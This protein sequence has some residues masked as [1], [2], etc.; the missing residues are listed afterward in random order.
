MELSNQ[1]LVPGEF[2]AAPR[3]TTLGWG[4]LRER[5]R[6]PAL[7]GS[8]LWTYATT[9]NAV[10]NEWPHAPRL[11]TPSAS[12][13]GAQPEAVCPA[14]TISG[15]PLALGEFDAG[16]MATTPVGRPPPSGFGPSG[17]FNTFGIN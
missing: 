15:A 5:V 17:V 2:G 3:P 13:F 1:P 14:T 9:I 6:R 10:R 8:L 11:G 7:S 4:S 12:G 16:I